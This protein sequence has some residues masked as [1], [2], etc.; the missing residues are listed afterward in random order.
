M[1]SRVVTL[2]WTDVSEVRTTSIIRAMII[3]LTMKAVHASET[4]V[5]FNLTSGRY[6]PEDSNLHTRRRENLKSHNIKHSLLQCDCTDCNN[7]YIVYVYIV[8]TY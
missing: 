4:S 5:H 2:K 7:V 8:R 3:A 6:I 1:Y